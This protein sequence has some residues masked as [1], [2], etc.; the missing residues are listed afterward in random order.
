[1]T[2]WINRLGLAFLMATI[3]SA[4]AYADD[5]NEGI[6][7]PAV[8]I[9]VFGGYNLSFGDWDLH[10]NA[11]QGESPE[12]A[13]IFGLR[14]GFQITDWLAFEVN[15][16]FIPF[17]GTLAGTSGLA[18]NYS[19]DFLISPLDGDWSPHLTLGGGIYQAA[20]GDFG[21]DAD[22]EIHAGLGIRGMLTR[23]LALRIEG[24]Y[25][26]T[27]AYTDGFANV[28]DIVAGVDIFAW[29]GEESGPEPDDD[30]DGV[31]NSEDSCPET[32][33]SVTAAGCPDADGDGIMD[34]KDKCPNKP[35]PAETG[36]CPDSDGDGLTDDVDQCPETPGPESEQ[37]CP[38]APK[39]ADGDGL[40]DNIDSCPNDPGPESTGG[41][42]DSD[43]DGIADQ[44][45]KCPN[46]PGVASE[47]GCLPKALKRFTGAIKGIYFNTGSAEIKRKSYN[48][49]NSAAK[50]LEKF[51]ALRV[52]IEGHTDSQGSDESNQTLSQARA[53]SVKAYFE[54]RG[55][56]LARFDAVG[57]GETKPVADNGTKAGRAKNRRIEFT[58]VG[59]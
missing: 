27:D 53:E 4:T 1:M 48:V 32:P 24:R 58:I 37:G 2:R 50:V 36:G 3:V 46:T 54:G 23:W 21:D 39:D 57:Y 15:G 34:A 38:E 30:N 22:W 45:D 14:L 41:C 56:D 49:L 47:Q 20:S 17:D 19:G 51:P 33:G 25:H 8:Y 59:N 16:G 13:P 44:D 9:G 55:L 12:N 5:H 42:P 40:S 43:G 10:E 35:G 31:P 18:A 52:R 28:I 29:T 6:P 7:N 26:L 11:D